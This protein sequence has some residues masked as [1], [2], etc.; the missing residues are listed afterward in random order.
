MNR[1]E[2]LESLSSSS[3]HERFRAAH[4]LTKCAE[5]QD[6]PLLLKAKHNEHDTYVLMRLDSAITHAKLVSEKYLSLNTPP[7]QTF[8]DEEM[9]AHAKA[10]AIEWVGGLLLHEIGSKLGL[11]SLTA[12][13]EVDAYELS[14]THRHIKNLQSIFDAI[15][16]LRRAANPAK[17]EQFDLAELI[18]EIY[19]IE[20]QGSNVE[21]SLV[22]IRPLMVTSSKQLIRLALCNGVR[23]AIEAVSSI[24]R[25]TTNIQT[26]PIVITW[27]STDSEHWIS[28]IDDGAGIGGSIKSIFDIGKSTKSGHPGFGLAIAKQAVDT[29]GGKITLEAS[30][31][32]GAKYGLRWRINQ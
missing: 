32:R 21:F 14:D 4:A 6:I 9:M 7:P 16:Q 22:G 18:E 29:L 19:K 5:R 3:S 26:S 20:N 28:V 15:E 12:S 24:S 10:Q 23:N 2:A 30:N 13:T 31:G 1:T 27:G 8:Q 25:S 17:Y 11:I